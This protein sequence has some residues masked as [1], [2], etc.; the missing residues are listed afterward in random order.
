MEYEIDSK[1]LRKVQLTQLDI[2][3]E[4]DRLCRKNNISY[5]LFAGTLLGAIRHEGFIPWDDDIDVAMTRN[6]YEKFLKICNEE[7]NSN[8]FLQNYSTDPKFFR[9]FSRIRKNNTRYVQKHYKDIDIHHGIFMDVFPLDDVMPNKITEEI[10][11]KILL[12]FSVANRIRNVGVFPNANILKQIV[13]KL[14][15]LTN[16]I[17]DKSTFENIERSIM[18]RYEQNHSNHMTLLT[19]ALEQKSYKR[20]LIGK[21]D[22]Y[23]VIYWNFEG[24]KFPIPKEY[25]YV[26][27]NIY[28][29]YMTP[30]PQEQQKPHH[31]IVEINF[32]TTS[33]IEN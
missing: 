17:V 29:D 13:G 21:E 24:Y 1:I 18:K 8:Y 9:Q 32:D 27:T 30:P 14:I 16:I 19:D 4:F 25:D 2:L 26:L 20:F 5:Q 7:L 6:D 3:I 10:R 11:Y 15:Q 23:D 22:F 12:F 33:K 31:G 28:G